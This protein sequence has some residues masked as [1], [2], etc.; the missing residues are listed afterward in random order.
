MLLF[1]PGES[2][3]P[4]LSSAAGLLPD[5]AVV[6]GPQGPLPAALTATPPVTSVRLDNGLEVLLAPRP[7]LPLVSVGVALGGGEVSGKPGVAELVEWVAFRRSDYQGQPG[8]YGLR[9]S[10]QLYRD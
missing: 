3:V 6:A 5:D 7:G 9:G 2:G 1:K 4:A 8:D 10:R